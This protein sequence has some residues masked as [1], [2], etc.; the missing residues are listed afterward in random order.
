MKLHSLAALAILGTALSGCASIVE[1]SSQDIALNTDA[2]SGATCKVSNARGDWTATTPGSVNVKR[3]KSAMAVH[4]TKDGYQEATKTVDSG[5]EP[6]TI[7]NLAIGGLIGIGI[8]AG[9]GSMNRYPDAVTVTMTPTSGPVT[10]D[11]APAG[12]PSAAPAKS[13][14][15]PSS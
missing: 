1:G 13:S 6:W 7:G 3:S 12:G 5:F 10:S 11:N 9:T 14:S 8:D 4:C 2:V 15:A